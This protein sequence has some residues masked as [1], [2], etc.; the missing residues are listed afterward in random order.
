MAPAQTRT[1]A[2][3]LDAAERAFMRDAYADVR[4]EDLAEEADVSVGS[5]YNL[6]ANKDGL[7]LAV[8]ERAVDLFGE[9]IQ[10]AYATSDPRWSRS[11]PAATPTCASTSSTRGRSG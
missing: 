10:H 1:R 3:M 7:Y 5:I 2:A 9:Y 8:V 11:W 6:F 4:I